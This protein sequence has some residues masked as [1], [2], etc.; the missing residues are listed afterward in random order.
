MLLSNSSA[1][2]TQARSQT[3]SQSKIYSAY[4][5][6]SPISRTGASSPPSYRSS[7]TQA[8]TQS[9]SPLV[10]DGN[11]RREPRRTRRD[12]RI[13]FPRR[14]IKT[15]R[16]CRM[17]QEQIQRWRGCLPTGCTSRGVHQACWVENHLKNAS[18]DLQE[19]RCAIL[20]AIQ[21]GKV[22]VPYVKEH[23]TSY[24]LCAW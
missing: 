5:S 4:Q 18:F 12:E 2:Q 24:G 15:E 14:S 8:P 3:G 19:T 11:D 13:P 23:M 9:S 10:Q 17:H 6:A 21:P 16:R 7:A 20:A 22:V 1:Q